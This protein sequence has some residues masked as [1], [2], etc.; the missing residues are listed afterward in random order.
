MLEKKCR[1][2]FCDW[3]GSYKDINRDIAQDGSFTLFIN[4]CPECDHKGVEMLGEIEES[5]DE[6]D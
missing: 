3:E 5:V 2:N 1:C 6:Q 4:R